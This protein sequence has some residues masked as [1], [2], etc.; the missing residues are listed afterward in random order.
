MRSLS[1]NR[2]TFFRDMP[3][4]WSDDREILRVQ[5]LEVHGNP[6]SCL[7][8]GDQLENAHRIDNTFRQKVVVIRYVFPSQPS[9]FQRRLELFKHE[10]A[11]VLY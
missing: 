10:G 1:I 8:L 5:V 4:E 11:D 6:E 7:D 3:A 2:K 9:G